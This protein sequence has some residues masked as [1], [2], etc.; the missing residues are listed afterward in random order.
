MEVSFEAERI[1]LTSDRSDGGEKQIG[2]L[3]DRIWSSRLK[4]AENDDLVLF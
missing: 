4:K 2:N 1:G 3:F